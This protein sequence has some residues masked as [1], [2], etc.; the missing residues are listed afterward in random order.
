MA[1]YQ[2]PYHSGDLVHTGDRFVYEVVEDAGT[3][4]IEVTPAY[5]HNTQCGEQ[6]GENYIYLAT[7]LYPGDG[8]DG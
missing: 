4:Q 3:D 2:R 1:D 7:S 6:Q 8:T 5:G